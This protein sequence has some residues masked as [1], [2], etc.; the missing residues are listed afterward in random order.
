MTVGGG[1]A[2]CPQAAAVA[3][4]STLRLRRRACDRCAGVVA[5]QR[6]RR[7]RARPP[8]FC[9]GGSRLDFARHIGS[10]SR[11][12]A[13][14]GCAHHV[15]CLRAAHA[16]RR[17]AIRALA[18]RRA[19]QPRLPPHLAAARAPATSNNRQTRRP[20]CA[21]Q[22]DG[23]CALSACGRQRRRVTFC[24][25]CGSPATLPERVLSVAASCLLHKH[26]R[27]RARASWTADP[28][29]RARSAA[30]PPPRPR[31]GVWPCGLLQRGFGVGGSWGSALTP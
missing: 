10:T 29:A 22:C 9:G 28:P 11:S 4:L 18:P 16:R 13:A 27:L 17:C 3:R 8:W 30:T 6:A 7:R 20:T 2:S 15:L 26:P 5:P 19:C 21:A 1:V 23:R 31:N 12:P 14:S 24:D 25:I